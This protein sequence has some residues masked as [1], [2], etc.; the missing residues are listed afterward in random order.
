MRKMS[1]A[2]L[3]ISAMIFL[4]TVVTRF[5][6]QQWI[7]QLWY[8]IAGSGLLLLA[9]VVIDFKLFA[10]FFTMRT[11]KHGMNMG[12]MI[13]LCVA[14]LV[15]I[16]FIAVKKDKRFDWTKEGLNSLA[17]QSI[18]AVQGFTE[19]VDVFYLYQPNGNP[20]ED[21]RAHLQDL[22]SKYSDINSKISFKPYNARTN[23]E[24]A[25]KF[26]YKQGA[27]G[28]Y[29]KKGEKHVSVDKVDEESLTKA[30]LKLNRIANKSL[31]FVVGHGE[32]EIEGSNPLGL[33]F[34]GSPA[35]RQDLDDLYQ[36][37]PLNLGEA[38][39]VPDDAAMLAIIGPQTGYSELEMTVLKNYA[40]KGGKFLIAIDPEFQHGMAN[41]TKF[42][43]VE[44][45]NQYILDPTQPVRGFGLQ[46]VVGAD[47]SKTNDATK[48]LTVGK[49]VFL[50]ASPI[51]R[52]PDAPSSFAV[53][54]LVKSGSPVAVVNSL[55]IEGNL[56]PTD[57]Q[58]IGVTVK[59]KIPASTVVPQTSKTKIVSDEQ[60]VFDLA[61]ELSQKEGAEFQAIIFGDSDFLTAR[62]F[63]AGVN[64]D[65][66][67]NSIAYLAKDNEMISVRP[68]K[69]SASAFA[70]TSNQFLIL[71]FSFII[72]FPLILFFAGGFVWWRRRTA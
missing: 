59:G 63:Q 17:E 21:P 38:K 40:R 27:S 2:L 58:T 14:L 72:P 33:S 44:F 51:Q 39:S 35:L 32:R 7:P 54:T 19:P 1:K 24:I 28:I 34:Q 55:K 46:A 57:A 42:L 52:A 9:I 48:S 6:L 68:K 49:P 8:P 36:V 60:K 26:G 12:V 41:F 56:E 47:L 37:K 11:T 3:L 23:P 20:K 61:K 69:P 5:V 65:L 66:A 43:G 29:A 71:L 53:D 16:N 15:A 62:F 18:K 30:F 13:L 4:G 10:E 67:M 45:R 31:Y 25:E 22:V 70:I 50:L 64:R